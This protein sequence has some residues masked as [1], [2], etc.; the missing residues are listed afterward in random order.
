MRKK[1]TSLLLSL[2]MC[3]STGGIVTIPVIAGELPFK[4]VPQNQ[5]K[6]QT[7]RLVQ[8]AN[9]PYSKKQHEKTTSFLDKENS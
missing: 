2:V 3:F 5:C 4:D 9:F 6:R 8:L 7:I 1:I